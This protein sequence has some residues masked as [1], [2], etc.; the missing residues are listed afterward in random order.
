MSM[1]R[2]AWQAVADAAG[3]GE[4]TSLLDLGCGSGA[5]CGFAAARGAIAHGLDAEPDSIA[6]A[7]DAV[8]GG[9]FRLGMME[10]L[11]W[12]DASFDVVTA[13]NAM[14]YAL[15]P[16]LAMAEASRVVRI[17]GRL[18]VC[19]WG[20]PAANQFFAFLA[21]VGANGVRAQPLVGN[22]PLQDVIR[23]ANLEVLVT[24]D[25][26]AAIEMADD[27]A[28][29]ESLSRAGI[30]PEVG[31]S[32]EAQSLVAAAAPYRQ[33]DGSYRFDNHLSFWVLRRSW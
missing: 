20:P 5:F 27:G 17:G 7:M 29:E 1:F 16:D 28:L 25:V 10:T 22:D 32:T 31:A 4:G 33:V 14:Q 9:E 13:F 6:Q 18:A 8:P 3:I 15:D 23:A 11:P 21:A 30:V 12:S 24:G 26:P 19:K 2:P